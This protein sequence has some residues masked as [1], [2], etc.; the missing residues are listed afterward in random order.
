MVGLTIIKIRGVKCRKASKC[1]RVKEVEIFDKK[2][3]GAPCWESWKI[4]REYIAPK[5]VAS[6]TIGKSQIDQFIRVVSIIISP[7]KLGEGG[8]P[9]FDAHIKSHH[10]VLNGKSNFNPRV[11]ASVRVPFRS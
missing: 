3:F 11:I 10:I 8:R 5:T 1:S 2:L 9:K 6:P 7:I 4:I